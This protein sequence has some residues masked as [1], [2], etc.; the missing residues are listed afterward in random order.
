MTSISE[1]TYSLASKS[2]TPG[3][4]GASALSG[5]LASALGSMV[6]ELTKGKKKYKAFEPDIVRISETIRSIME[7]LLKC[8]DED[9]E[10]FAPLSKAYSISADDP[11]RAA[12]LEKCLIDAARVP[13][14]I[15]TFSCRIVPLLEELEE[16]GSKLVI[17]DV[18]SSAALC[19]AA[20][21]A[22]A[23]NVYI[24]TKLMTN[25]EFANKLNDD[26]R[27]LTEEHTSRVQSVYD[28]IT[29]GIANWQQS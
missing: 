8:I 27:K 14:K 16:K 4:G 12:V 9:A 21:Q 15:L 6:C 5:A 2:P 24:N 29:G 17:S 7:D 1:F 19:R 13:F 3:G 20:I 26:V 28:R 18:A 22:A 23:V 11:D 25:R 10:A